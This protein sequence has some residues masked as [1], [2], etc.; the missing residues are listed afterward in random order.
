MANNKLF[1]DAYFANFSRGEYQDL[2]KAQKELEDNSSWE[3]DVA[4]ISI[5]ALEDAMQAEVR[6]NDPNNTIPK[7]ILLDTAE[8]C[9]LMITYDG[10][11]ECLR[12]CAM[13]SL[14][15]TVG[16]RG[17][18][19]FRPT[20]YQ[21]SV[22]L[23]ALLTGCRTYSKVM[24]RGGKVSAIVSQKY[25]DMP[26]TELLDITDRLDVYL[27]TPEFI[28]GCVCHSL[29][30]AKFQY[31]DA[32][33]DV[34]DA[35]QSALA[36]H[37]RTLAPGETVTPI[38]EFRTSDTTG[39]AAKL[40]TYLQLS[41]GHLMP[42]GQ[43]VRVNHVAPYEFD[44]N[45]IRKTAMQKFSEEAQLLYS[46]LDYDIKVIVPAMLET[47]IEYPV[48]TFIGLCRKAQIPQK[49]GGL[50]EEEIRNDWPDGSG[51]TFL[52]VYEYLTSVTKKA[53][54]ENTPHSARLLELEEA[55]SRIANNRAIWKKYDLPGTVAWVQN[56]N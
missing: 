1:E 33:K 25:E 26:G 14:L 34:T 24:T 5:G 54:E 10:K 42:I 43:G 7:E 31:P 48:N 51:C 41:P 35:Y 18:G 37:G 12:D 49:W 21:Q 6:F 55:I 16:I 47:P 32:A 3:K 36:A 23:T 19:V 52:D 27:G 9:G 22:A 53:L 15:S 45:G 17:E 39:E 38:I 29:T 20:K 28:S 11:E 13:S 46:K 50:V 30:V 2:R 44:E 40:L 56:L 8:N 4:N